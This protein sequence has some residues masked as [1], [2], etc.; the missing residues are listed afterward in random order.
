MDRRKLQ[1]ALMS[2][3]IRVSDDDPL[4]I[5]LELNQI[6]FEEMVAIH[7]KTLDQHLISQVV[8]QALS[9]QPARPNQ[10]QC[11]GGGAVEQSTKRLERVIATLGQFE[12]KMSDTARDTAKSST[13][14]IVGQMLNKLLMALNSGVDRFDELRPDVVALSE[15]AKLTT[16]AAQKIYSATRRVE[17]WWLGFATLLVVTLCIG[18]YLG[19]STTTGAYER[20]QAACTTASIAKAV[21]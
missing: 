15:S 13:R 3:G 17:V 14:E 6:H 5:V 4:F 10:F 11:T 18:M 12:E 21:Q 20:V 9:K 2:R 8:S 16:V 1:L 7:F 19:H